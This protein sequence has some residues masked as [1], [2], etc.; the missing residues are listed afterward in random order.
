M[1]DLEIT[2]KNSD[3]SLDHYETDQSPENFVNDPYRI[4]GITPENDSWHVVV[5]YSGGCAN[6]IFSTWWDGNITDTLQVMLYHNS[7]GDECEALVR[8]TIQLDLKTILPNV[9]REKYTLAAI[10]A[11][12]NLHVYIDPDLAEIKQNESCTLNAQFIGAPCGNGL[13]EN[14]WFLIKDEKLGKIW[15]QPVKNSANVQLTKPETGNY[16]IGITM[17]FGHQLNGDTDDNCN[18]KPEGSVIPVAINCLEKTD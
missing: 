2:D 7:N 3:A 11:S 18:I 6:H 13:W 14:Q 9:E 12:N 10:N 15:L 8:D 16:K 1:S 4:V 17:L 5:E